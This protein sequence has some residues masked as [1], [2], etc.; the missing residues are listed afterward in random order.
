MP[1]IA[2]TPSCAFRELERVARRGDRRA[3]GEDPRHARLAGAL[4]DLL[5]RVGAR[6]EVRVR[7]DHAAVVGASTRGKSGCRRL[8]PVGRDR[9]CR[10]RRAPSA[11]SS[12]LAERLRGCR[13]AVSG[14]YAR[15]RDGTNGAAPSTSV[16]AARRVEHRRPLA[17]SFGRASPRSLVREVL[18]QRGATIARSPRARPCCEASTSRSAPPPSRT[19]P[20]PARAGRDRPARDPPVAVRHRVIAVVREHAVDEVFRRARARS[21]RGTN[22]ADREVAVLAFG[23]GRARRRSAPRRRRSRSRKSR[24]DRHVPGSSRSCPPSSGIARD[25]AVGE[26]AASAAP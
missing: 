8:D 16:I 6:V 21:A 20:R 18:V 4:D 5:G 25:Y 11:R 10:A 14:R 2:Y 15:E 22:S 12:R 3:D 19:R 26:R 9:R 17:S 13:G 24:R 7:V 23:P 1:R